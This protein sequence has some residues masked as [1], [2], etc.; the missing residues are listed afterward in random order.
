MPA[1][2][3]VMSGALRR[4]LTRAGCA[5]ALMLTLQ[6]CGYK[7]P[8]YHPPPPEPDATLTAPPSATSRP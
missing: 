2:T 4:S 3:H 7:G 5:V 6:G 8:L 1:Q